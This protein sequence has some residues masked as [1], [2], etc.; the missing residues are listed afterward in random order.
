MGYLPLKLV[1]G[2]A[3]Y[4]LGVVGGI[5]AALQCFSRGEVDPT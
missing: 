5:K 2:T 4:S 3:V 1:L